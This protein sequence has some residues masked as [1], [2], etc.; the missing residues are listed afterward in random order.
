MWPLNGG[1]PLNR[2]QTVI[3]NV[4]GINEIQWKKY[5]SALSSRACV[6]SSWTGSLQSLQEGQ[7]TVENLCR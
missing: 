1:S 6:A 7:R 3:I 2:G 5:G 4:N